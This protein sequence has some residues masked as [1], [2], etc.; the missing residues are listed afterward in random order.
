M[1]NLKRVIIPAAKIVPAE[2]QKLGKLPGIIYPINQKIAFDY[3]Y[4]EYKEYCMQ[5]TDWEIDH[6]LY[7]L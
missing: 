3:L 7:R 5:V 6:Y 2:L 4:E 1:D